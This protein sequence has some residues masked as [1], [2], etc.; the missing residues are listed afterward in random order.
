VSVCVKSPTAGP[1]CKPWVTTHCPF[2]VPS[3]THPR[4]A[5]WLAAHGMEFREGASAAATTPVGETAPARDDGTPAGR[6]RP[7]RPLC[8]CDDIDDG[9]TPMATVA[10]LAAARHHRAGTARGPLDASC[11]VPP[12][13]R[14]AIVLDCREPVQFRICALRGS[15]NV[16]LRSLRAHARAGDL[17]TFLQ[18]LQ[19]EAQD[20]EGSDGAVDGLRLQPAEQAPG[21]TS[22]S[23]SM[24]QQPL[25]VV[26]RRGIDSLDAARVRRA[27]R[28]CGVGDAPRTCRV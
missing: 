8:A 15:V 27:W 20:V 13:A 4:S 19:S 2:C 21:A 23:T 1:P 10:E 3:L 24:L 28:S 9:I 22:S 7:T 18:R 6:Q 17:L 25:Y 5:D 26:C 16:P 14:P 11:N 12:E